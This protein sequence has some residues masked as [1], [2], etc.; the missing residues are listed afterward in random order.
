M[1]GKH[2]ETYTCYFGEAAVFFGYDHVAPCCIT[3]RPNS[4]PP[5]YID[6]LHYIAETK[7]AS[8]LM[9]EQSKLLN[10]TLQREECHDCI[11]RKKSSK[12][13]LE[14]FRH[15]I[16][17]HVEFCELSC[18]YCYQSDINYPKL[19]RRNPYSL[20]ATMRDLFERGMIDENADFFWGGGEPMSSPEFWELARWINNRSYQQIINTHGVKLHDRLLNDYFLEHLVIVCSVDAGS[21]KTYEKVKGVG[22]YERVWSN[23]IRYQELGANVVPKFIFLKENTNDASAFVSRASNSGHKMVSFDFDLNEV[24]ILDDVLPHQD[25]FESALAAANANGLQVSFAGHSWCGMSA[26]QIENILNC[27]SAVDYDYTMSMGPFDLELRNRLTDM[28][29]VCGKPL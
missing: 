26:E 16:L 19:L 2:S 4:H 24:F 13:K 18:I 23:L 17:S 27:L 14:R 9:Q 29:V 5:R 12:S 11:Y 20:L 8:L 28:Q 6:D 25:A 15:V 10:P 1:S 7:I 3:P 22:A 21:D